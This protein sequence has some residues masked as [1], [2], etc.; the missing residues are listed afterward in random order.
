MIM[1]TSSA[2]QVTSM[3]LTEAIEV[4]DNPIGGRFLKHFKHEPFVKEGKEIPLI[5]PTSSPWA[6]AKSEGTEATEQNHIA[7]ST[8]ILKPKRFAD[9]IVL[10][11][12]IANDSSIDHVKYARDLALQ[13]MIAGFS[14]Q[15]LFNGAHNDST[16]EIKKRDV[17]LLF[18]DANNLTPEGL[19]FNYNTM[20]TNGYNPLY[21]AGF[22]KDA[23]WFINS[24]ITPSIINPDTGDEM[25]KI[26]DKDKPEGAYA[27]FMGLPV[28]RERIRN[29]EN[30]NMAWGIACPQAYSVMISD[31]KVVET[32]P[33]TVQAIKGEKVY[34]IE[35]W[36]DGAITNHMAKLSRI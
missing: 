27:T 35:M 15:I 34:V 31:I 33:S 9:K 28:Y 26:D 2:P 4:S 17:Q 29:S 14:R 19:V 7:N 23:C 1:N 18:P 24:G 32:T 10:S 5:R 30:Q 6:T 13:R 25:L 12:Q 16:E 20:I 3:S 21:D 8:T 11:E 22:S 36:A